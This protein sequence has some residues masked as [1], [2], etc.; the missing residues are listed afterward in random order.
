MDDEIAASTPIA[1]AHD[2]AGDLPR[3]QYG[4]D[5]GKTRKGR[6]KFSADRT[7]F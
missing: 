4:K 5:T 2:A 6:K 7:I 3:W 1:I